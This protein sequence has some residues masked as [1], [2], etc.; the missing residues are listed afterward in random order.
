MML[1]LGR[2]KLRKLLRKDAANASFSL[3][4]SDG[5]QVSWRLE[6]DAEL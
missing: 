1:A 2:E 3:L 6:H 5:L 4:G